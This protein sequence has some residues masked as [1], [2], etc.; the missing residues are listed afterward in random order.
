MASGNTWPAS[1]P[2]NTWLGVSTDP[3]HKAWVLQ[4]AT[5]FSP[6]IYLFFYL[7][8]LIPILMD[9]APFPLV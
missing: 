1:Q 3:L 6:L 5:G 8:Y 7:I 4:V 9:H 2:D